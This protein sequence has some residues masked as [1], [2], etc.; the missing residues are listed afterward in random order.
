[1][2]SLVARAQLV[3][4]VA[5]QYCEHVDKEGRFPSEAVRAMKEARLLS[6]FIP[7][8]FGGDALL[9]ASR[10]ELLPAKASISRCRPG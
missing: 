2:S 5:A 7:R 9:N 8:E 6:A 4:T 3:G 10:L 1:M